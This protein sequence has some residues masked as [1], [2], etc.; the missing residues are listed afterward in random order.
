ML[1]LF[2]KSWLVMKCTSSCSRK[3]NFSCRKRCFTVYAKINAQKKCFCDVTYYYFTSHHRSGYPPWISYILSEIEFLFICLPDMTQ[4]KFSQVLQRNCEY[5]YLQNLKIIPILL[6]AAIPLST[7][8]YV[9][10]DSHVLMHT[11]TF[12]VQITNNSSFTT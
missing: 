4:I 3:L 11:C 1:L 10:L 7:V 12:I 2:R 9:R 5:I 8:F 6:D